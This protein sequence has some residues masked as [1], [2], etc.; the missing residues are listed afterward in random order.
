M[1]WTLLLVLGAGLALAG[2]ALWYASRARFRGGQLPWF[3]LGALLVVWGHQILVWRRPSGLDEDAFKAQWER[4]L[5]AEPVAPEPAE[6]FLS[7]GPL[8]L[9]LPSLGFGLALILS[10]VLLS[11]CARSPVRM[12]RLAFFGTGALVMVAGLYVLALL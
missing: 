5:A 11:W 3:G 2:G 1:D 7:H 8:D 4:Y 12:E 9:L 6:A 10:F